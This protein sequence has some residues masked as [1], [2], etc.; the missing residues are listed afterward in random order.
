MSGIG[1]RECIRTLC[2]TS[3]G[4]MPW[5]VDRTLLNLS[6]TMCAKALIKY[7]LE[8]GETMVLLA[9]FEADVWALYVSTRSYDYSS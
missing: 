7:L 9:V 1:L 3:G 2:G 6:M 8:K 5:D 4:G